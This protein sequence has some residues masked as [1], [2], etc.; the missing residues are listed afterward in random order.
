MEM[1]RLIVHD[2]EFSLALE[3]T[4]REKGIPKSLKAGIMD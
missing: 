1:I 4:I 2:K 3:M